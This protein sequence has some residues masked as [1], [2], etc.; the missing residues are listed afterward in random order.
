MAPKLAPDNLVLPEHYMFDLDRHFLNDSIFPLTHHAGEL[1]LTPGSASKKFTPAPPLPSPYTDKR[2]ITDIR[3]GSELDFH[4][5]GVWTADDTS[6]GGTIEIKHYRGNS[7]KMSRVEK[8]VLLCDKRDSISFLDATRRQD[9]FPGSDIEII[10][11]G[12]GSAI[13]N[14]CR[15]GT[16]PPS[17][18]YGNVLTSSF[19]HCV[20]NT[21]TRKYASRLWGRISRII[22]TSIHTSRIPTI[23]KT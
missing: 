10:T 18:L 13:P 8:E 15:N 12:T 23:L 11:L 2:F 6:N 16:P 22:K 1:V 3:V 20:T 5:G 17:L 7:S 9:P 14:K 21:G 4:H 19:L